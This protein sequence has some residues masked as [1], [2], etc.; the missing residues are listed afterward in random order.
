MNNKPEIIFTFPACM[1]GVASFNF[2]I[3]NN[4]SLIKLFYSKVILLKSKED[5]RPLFLESFKADEVII[6]HYS[7][8]EN[9]HYVKKR[10][11]KLLGLCNGAI[12][13]DNG[14]TITAA[15][16]FNNPKTIFHLIH[17]FFY[18][19]QNIQLTDLADVAIA[20]SSFFSDAVFAANPVLFS[21]R[22]FYIPYGVKCLPD[23]PIKKDDRINLV[24]LGRLDEGKGVLKL[25]EIEKKLQHDNIDVYWTIVGKG[26]FKN[27]LHKQWS[28][29]INV[30]FKEPNTTEEVYS[31]LALQDILVLPTSFEGTPVSILECL[32][33]GV[34]TITND[35][36]GG[37]RDI[38]TEDIGFKCSINDLD[39]F[40]EKIK[41]LNNDNHKLKEL[42][43]NCYELS[44]NK[45][46]IQNNAA[47]FFSLFLEFEKYIR[48]LKSG[49]FKM[50]YL[51]KSIFPNKVVKLIR[52]LK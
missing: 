35:L 11:N 9:Q 13:T 22:S 49:K 25:I 50:S 7:D 3:I 44:K 30:S 48:P 24:F 38:V 37:I 14:L 5:N 33:N 32:A 21:N 34:V 52:N 40:V 47:N 8:K 20:H 29:N 17:D 39:E 43:K 15:K 16:L 28:A 26:P 27:E 45:Y 31:I 42:Q 41:F 12:V 2:N 10:L 18:V 23:L 4:S 19:N 36:P 1:G 46:D 6:F 51:D